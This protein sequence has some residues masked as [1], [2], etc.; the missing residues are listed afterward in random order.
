VPIRLLI[1]DDHAV[2]RKGLRQYFSEEPDFEVV[3]E[4]RDG[5]EVLAEVRRTR[6]D[7]AVLDLKMPNRNGLEVLEELKAERAAV[8]PI[9]LAAHISEDEVLQAMRLG[10]RGVILKEMAP[11]LLVQCVR[12]VHAGGQW[13][14]KESL[15]RALDRMIAAEETAQQ[16][17]RVLTPREAEIARGICRGLANR[18]IADELCISEGTVK[19]HLHTI[20][21]KLEVRGR[22]QLSHFL[23]ERGFV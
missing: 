21:D 15:G 5:A 22:L 11:A 19:T 4:C 23:R 10:V 14:E 9:L 16:I 13:L 20:Y 3:A 2:V 6:P 7:V 12:K 8:R 17:T 1:A 18:Q